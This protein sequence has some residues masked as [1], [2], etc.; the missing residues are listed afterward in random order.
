M[1]AFTSLA[2]LVYKSPGTVQWANSVKTNE[3]YF[4]RATISTWVRFDGSTATLTALGALNVA[5]IIDSGTGVYV[6][7]FTTAYQ[8]SN[9]VPFFSCNDPSSGGIQG[10]I[11]NVRGGGIP[12]AVSATLMKIQCWTNNQLVVDPDLVSVGIIGTGA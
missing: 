7:V 2:T 10:V 4:N 9:Y 11:V 1:S 6:V 3:D 5:N 12:D 8:N